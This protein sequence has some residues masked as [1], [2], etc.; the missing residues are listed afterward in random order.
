MET[1]KRV[2]LMGSNE[3][4]SNDEHPNHFQGPSDSGIDPDFGSWGE[5]ADTIK[6]FEKSDTDLNQKTHL[7]NIKDD[8]MFDENPMFGDG[9]DERLPTDTLN[10]RETLTRFVME[11]YNDKKIKTQNRDKRIQ[12]LTRSSISSDKNEERQSRS[13]ERPGKSSSI[14]QFSSQYQFNRETDPAA[15]KKYENEVSMSKLPLSF[16]LEDLVREEEK[17][18][19]IFDFLKREWDPSTLCDEWWELSEESCLMNVNKYFKEEKLVKTIN[20]AMKLQTIVIGYTHFMSNL[21]PFDSLIKNTFKNLNNYIHENFMLIIVFFLQRLN[22]DVK[23]K[24]RYAVSLKETLKKNKVKMSIT[25]R[26]AYMAMKH[27]N[28]IINKML[29]SAAL[30]KPKR[31]IDDIVSLILKNL[32]MLDV[33]KVRRFIH[34]SSRI[35]TKLPHIPGSS[36][37]NFGGDDNTSLEGRN[38]SGA[39]KASPSTTESKTSFGAIM[40]LPPGAE[41]P[42]SPFLPAK[43]MDEKEYTLVL[44]LDETLIHFVDMGQDS[45]F[46]IRPG[47]Q[48]FLE[49]MYKYYEIV[50]FT[51]GMKD[52]ADWV[53]DQFDT[54]R[55]IKHRLYRHHVRQNGVYLVKDLGKIG[56]NLKKTL[57]VDNVAENFAKQPDNGIFIRT[58]YNDMDDT[59]LTDLIPLLKRL[60]EDQVEDVGKALRKYRDQIIR[61]ITAGVTNPDTEVIKN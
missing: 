15:F 27:K 42:K 29:K 51:A 9:S 40:G 45:Y 59:C 60:V 28:D 16:N 56:R 34:N 26:E 43:E 19:E 5:K 30:G 35:K 25:K 24:N 18:T 32:K 13:L 4:F 21:F 17:L 61:L 39:A 33:A 6:T 12:S 10:D 36:I 41:I 20:N 49:E 1:N 58:W 55:Y 54:N 8:R 7:P 14:N 38:E 46:L 48:Q 37:R 11:E 23:N 52:Y 22:T 57:I 31:S 44:D 53:L 50:V 47:A 3:S 2:Q